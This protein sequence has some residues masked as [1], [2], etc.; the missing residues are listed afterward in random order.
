MMEDNIRNVTPKSK[1][2][3]YAL[4]WFVRVQDDWYWRR[5]VEKMKGITA[6][7]ERSAVISAGAIAIS[8]SA[9]LFAGLRKSR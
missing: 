5:T 6:L 3:R 4:E 1:E 2:M 7:A 8:L 9:L